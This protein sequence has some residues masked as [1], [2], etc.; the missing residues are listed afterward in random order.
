M[1]PKLDM[2][3]VFELD[4]DE[5]DFRGALTG[6]IALGVALALVG[7]LGPVAMAAGI[8][9]IFVV[10]GDSDETRGP[11]SVQVALVLAGTAI[12]LAVGY[13][14]ASAVAATI[15]IALVTLG[16]T[17]GAKAGARPAAAGTYALLW[18]VLTLS[19]GITD[20]RP[21]AMALAFAAGGMIALA[22][23]WLSERVPSPNDQADGEAAQ[24]SDQAP[25][26][27]DDDSAGPAPGAIELFAVLRALAAGACVGLGYWLFADHPAWA[28]LTFV[29]VLQP[30]K[31]Q[32]LV[33]G[34]GRTLG[35]TAGVL[36]GMLV[37]SVVEDQTA[38]LVAAFVICGFLM[39]ATKKV[40]YALS[41]TFTTAMLL[42]AGRLLQDD[43]FSTGATRLLATLLGVVA[44]FAVFVA[45]QLIT[46]RR[47][48]SRDQT[49]DT[50]GKANRDDEG[51]GGGR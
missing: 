16:A 2:R 24:A 19:I 33:V 30:P 34:V 50:G 8:A 42:L 5:L 10:A 51:H 14:A 13:A 39:L 11:D 35:T 18:A 36:V 9:A 23:L 43:V 29:L 6:V 37:A 46:N 48:G 7:T 3:E 12:T 20:E 15:T 26:P 32:A 41:T 17:L 45:L 25:A 21:A 4:R 38:A 27:S 47:V 22:A 31:Q 49:H 28:V 40:N 1:A 44:A